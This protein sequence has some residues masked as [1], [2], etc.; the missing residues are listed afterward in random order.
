MVAR[1]ID[2]NA[3]AADLKVHLSTEVAR[4]TRQGTRPGLATVI[5]G[6][7]Y[8][9]GAYER[10]VRRLAE[11][12]GCHYACEAMPAHVE[13][14]D[15]VLL[16]TRAHRTTR[17]ELRAAGIRYVLAAYTDVHGVGKAKAVPID[18]F[19]SMMRGAE[20]FTGAALDCATEFVTGG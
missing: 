13:Q 19:T 17:D 2:G 7:S 5:V 10:R 1:I 9:A 8:A 11:E 16:C 14:A 18:H 20:L 3:Y 4:L 15:A 6:D 12:L